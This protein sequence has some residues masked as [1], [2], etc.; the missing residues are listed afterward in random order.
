MLHL[1]EMGECSGLLLL[2]KP[3]GISSNQA[4]QQVKRLFS[5]KKAGHTGCLDPLASGMLI[6]CFNQATKLSQFLLNE[7]KTY[8]VTARLGVTTNT[9]D[10]EGM[11]EQRRTVPKLSK[12]DLYDVLNRFVGMS[13]QVPP[14]FSALKYRGRPLYQL[15]RNGLQ[16]TRNPRSIFV[17]AINLLDF[18]ADDLVLEITCSKGTY[19]RTLIEDIGDVLGCGAHVTRLRRLKVGDYCSSQLKTLDALRQLSLE[20]RWKTLISI[21][22][23]LHTWRKLYLSESEAHALIQGRALSG[24]Q[25]EPGPIALFHVDG[26]ALGIGEVRNDQLCSKRVLIV[27]R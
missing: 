8:L 23:F 19:I 18:S 10:S 2:D 5:A 9:G 1:I 11:I 21:E 16:V 20:E 6:V 3:S 27:M 26:H 15:A 22:S 7:N 25:Q 4:L 14:M 12:H 24:Y 17:E 13:Q